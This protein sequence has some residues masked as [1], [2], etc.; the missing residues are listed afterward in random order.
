M[1][2]FTCRLAVVL[3]FG[4]SF[5]F[6]LRADGGILVSS[7]PPAVYSGIS[8]SPGQVFE[9]VATGTV[10]LSAT[11]GSYVTD[12]DGT[13]VTAPAPGSGADMFFSNEPP[14]VGVS[15]S[16]G[17]FKLVG[18]SADDVPLPNAR[19]G[20]LTAGFSPTLTPTSYSD[21]VGGFAAVGTGASITAPAGGGFLF[22]AVNDGFGFEPRPDN[23][24][25]F[26]VRIVPEPGSIMLLGLAVALGI[27]KR[28][29]NAVQLRL[30]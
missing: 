30:R 7:T 4:S 8:A 28:N 23:E 24:G 16:V 5:V 22:F 9:I 10:D 26:D 25:E 2:P 11:N 6:A 14:D 15:P 12:A 1:K 18:P 21:F 17:G 13:I 3:V 29:P 27:A 19:Y 20:L